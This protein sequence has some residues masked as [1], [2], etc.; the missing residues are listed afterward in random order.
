MGFDSSATQ[1]FSFFK[2][3]FSPNDLSHSEQFLFSVKK[4][5]CLHCQ[6]GF[7]FEDV[8]YSQVFFILRLSLFLRLSFFLKLSS[9]SSCIQ[10]KGFIYFQVA[11][12]SWLSSFWRLSSFQRLSSFSEYCECISTIQFR[13]ITIN[14]I[15]PPNFQSM[16]MINEFD[17]ETN[18]TGTQTKSGCTTGI[19]VFFLIPVGPELDWKSENPVPVLPESD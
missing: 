6:I 9:I 14:Y 11:F 10:F 18:K 15:K 17:Q 8:F 3:I 7:I 13:F 19:P 1:S 4:Q 2:N 16:F 12:S 5:F